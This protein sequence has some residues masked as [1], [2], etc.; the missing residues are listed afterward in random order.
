VLG[1]RISN[2]DGFNPD[3]N[4]KELSLSMYNF[5]LSLSDTLDYVQLIY[6]NILR[7]ELKA[8]FFHLIEI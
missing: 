4:Q 6:V 5:F 1:D 8:D 7:I 3:N 2:L